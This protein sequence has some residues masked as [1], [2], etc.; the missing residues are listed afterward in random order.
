MF[1][2]LYGTKQVQKIHH[3]EQSVI[4]RHYDDDDD[5]ERFMIYGMSNKDKCPEVFWH[6]TSTMQI[7]LS[8]VVYVVHQKE[9]EKWILNK[10]EK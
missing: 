4:I 6:K 2:D 1:V 10:S 7:L 8:S 9:K 5:D 3:A